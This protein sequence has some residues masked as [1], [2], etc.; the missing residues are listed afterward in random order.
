MVWIEE[1]RPTDGGA[2]TPE[3]KNPNPA[4]PAQSVGFD[5]R[6]WGQFRAKRIAHSTG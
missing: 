2:E 5:L 6:P 1:T 4:N 3:R